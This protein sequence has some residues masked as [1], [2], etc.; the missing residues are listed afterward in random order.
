LNLY[1][2][3]FNLKFDDIIIIIIII[4]VITIKIKKTD[5]SIVLYNIILIVV[6]E[7]RNKEIID[8][9]RNI[10]NNTAEIESNFIKITKS[11]RN[12]IIIIAKK[13]NKIKK[14]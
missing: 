12:D 14:R 7:N 4:I 2:Y 1:K 8:I 5:Q 6:F 13:K 9:F 3:Q 11:N 10:E